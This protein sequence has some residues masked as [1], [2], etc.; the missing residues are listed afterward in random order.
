MIGLGFLSFVTIILIELFGELQWNDVN[1]SLP[2]LK[3]RSIRFAIHEECVDRSWFDVSSS[4]EVI[5]IVSISRLTSIHASSNSVGCIVAG[6]AGYMDS[7][8]LDSSPAI[9]FL[10]SSTLFLLDRAWR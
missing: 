3:E 2:R 7:S 8:A 6:A 9:T 5:R 1:R 10:C 4:D